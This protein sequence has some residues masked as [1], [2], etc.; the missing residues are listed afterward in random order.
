MSP[1]MEDIPLEETLQSVEEG[2]AIAGSPTA[3]RRGD[4]VVELSPPPPP[5]PP[6]P[7]KTTLLVGVGG[8]LALDLAAPHIGQ[9]FPT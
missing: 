2:A 5:P 4:A 6:P 3:K 1:S 7:A 9:Q 8:A